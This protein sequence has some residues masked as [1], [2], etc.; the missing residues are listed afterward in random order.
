MHATLIP[1]RISSELTNTIA[2]IAEII[3]QMDGI[4]LKRPNPRLRR[5]NRIESIHAS[6]SIEGNSLTK[7]QVTA[8]LD[9]QRVFGP[10]K[11]ILEV[12]NALEMYRRIGELD[13]FSTDSLLTA[14]AIMMKDLVPDAGYLR[15]GPIG[16]LRENNIWHEAP[17]WRE[18]VPK[19]RTL[20][21]YMKES[22]DHL[23]IKSSYFHFQLEHIH[24][25]MDGNGRMGRLWQT[26]I[27]MA[28]H[29]IFEYIPVE[30]LIHENQQTYYRLIAKGE[31]KG[32]C[33]GFITF[34]LIQINNALTQL[35]NETRNVRLSA[36]DRLD[37]AETAFDTKHFSRKNYQDLFKTISTA[38]AS[39][40]LK[41]GVQRH[42]LVRT[43]DKRTATYHFSA[44]G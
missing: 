23:L 20:F 31:D 7:G 2:A 29:P 8:L 9:D 38:T 3:G 22:Q 24:P 14:H 5:K 37:I 36:E 43:G 30:H 39:R 44:K 1:F 18:V 21:R 17:A 35:M 33:T 11:D 32:D 40:D 19:I 13:G 6:L 26:L 27:L 42:R 10:E 28:Y 15:Q 16:I 41:K 12:Q 4:N 34:I 25:F